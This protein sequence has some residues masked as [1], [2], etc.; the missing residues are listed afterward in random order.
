MNKIVYALYGVWA[1]T[2]ILLKSFG[3]G[4]WWL[5]TSFIWLPI[6]IILVVIMAVMI[7]TDIAK[8]QKDKNTPPPSCENCLFRKTMELSGDEQCLGEK[9]GIPKKDGVC[10]NWTSYK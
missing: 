2:C 4:S 6:A 3:I 10:A 7:T 1:L 9:L 8:K 5:A